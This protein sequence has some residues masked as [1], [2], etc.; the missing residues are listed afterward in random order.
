MLR[1]LAIEFFKLRHTR[2]FWI[3]AGLFGIL[4]V[5][6]PVGVH[7][8][9]DYLT[10]QGDTPLKQLGLDANQ[11]PL[12][13]FVDL[14]QNLT[15][16]YT[17]FS[18]FLGFISLISLGNEYSYGTLRQ[19][20]IDGLSPGELLRSKLYFIATLSLVATL[21]VFLTGLVCGY[22]WSPV[23]DWDFVVKHLEFLPAYWLHLCLF[24]LFCLC[25][26]MLIQR[27]GLTLA[28]L[29]FYVYA[30]EPILTLYLEYEQKVPW[31]ANLFPIR[32]MGKFIP[33]PFPK[34]LL[35]ETITTVPLPQLGVGLVYLGLLL[36]L[37]HWLMTKRDLR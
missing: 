37:A 5:A 4:L 14:W 27:T 3:L 30:I 7:A 6:I 2:F 11:I 8:F 35:N 21:V 16:T 10:A 15:W 9:L 19:N 29:M 24:Q 25:I 22:L 32:A 36:F 23:T 18:I 1:L 13:D 17:F 20:V 28:L 34:Y 26:A 33:N 12:F 31:L